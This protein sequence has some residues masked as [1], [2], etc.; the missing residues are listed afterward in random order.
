M[1]AKDVAAQLGGLCS[2]QQR[3]GGTYNVGDIDADIPEELQDPDPIFLVEHEQ[4]L[5]INEKKALKSIQQIV[6]TIVP[7]YYQN[8]AVIKDKMQQDA[9][10][11]GQLYYQQSMNNIMIKAIMDT[12]AKGSI[13]SR[14]FD[15]YTKLMSIAKDFNKQINEMQNQFRK[16]YIDTYL[17]LQHKE[18]EDQILEEH[19][20]TKTLTSTNKGQQTIIHNTNNTEGNI[21]LRETSTKDTVI[22]TQEWKKEIYRKKFEEEKAKAE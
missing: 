18:E 14:M 4:E 16:Y 9:T 10:Q 15:S 12:I 22:K 19:N 6:N 21:D 11:L 2:T 5:N 20:G 13:E 8:N 1:K 7:T 3:M 17:D